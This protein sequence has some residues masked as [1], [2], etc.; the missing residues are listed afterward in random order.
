MK[1]LEMSLL[2]GIVA[3]IIL[4]LL[5][6][7]TNT[8]SDVLPFLIIVSIVVAI[9][10]FILLCT[11]RSQRDLV[12][13]G[14]FIVAAAFPL[15]V[16][17]HEFA[18]WAV[19]IGMGWTNAAMTC[20]YMAGVTS[21]SMTPEQL[22]AATPWSLWIFY[23]AGPVLTLPIEAAFL[24]LFRD[25]RIQLLGAIMLIFN[26]FALCP[27]VSGN[28]AFQAQQILLESGMNEILVTILSYIWF[29]LAI[30]LLAVWGLKSISTRRKR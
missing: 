5:G 15:K 19:A 8:T 30:T 3:A 18:H 28:D 2:G 17:L 1:V 22:L 29:L 14:V 10:S 20:G 9:L 26:F 12:L 4:I 13:W 24:F 6:M 23:L 25:F 21:V 16:L 27:V 7:L 11:R